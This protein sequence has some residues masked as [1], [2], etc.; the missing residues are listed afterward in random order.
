MALG[1]VL[2]GLIYDKRVHRPSLIHPFK[3]VAMSYSVVARGLMPPAWTAAY[4]R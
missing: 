4:K 1:P 3:V 2:G